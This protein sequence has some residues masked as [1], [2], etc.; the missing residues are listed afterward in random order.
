MVSK[1][2]R[3]TWNEKDNCWWLLYL[4][5]EENNSWRFSKSWKTENEN[6][7]GDR[8]ISDTILS[9]IAELQSWGYDVRIV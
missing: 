9:D 1:I 5:D 2:A 8:W 4:W 3:V 7:N 6:I